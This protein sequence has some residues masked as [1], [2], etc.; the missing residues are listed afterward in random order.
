MGASGCLHPGACHF[1]V[2]SDRHL[3]GKSDRHFEGKSDRH[4]KG[5]KKQA[6]VQ[7]RLFPNNYNK[8]NILNNS[9]TVRPEFNL[10]YP[11]TV[12]RPEVSR[13]LRPAGAC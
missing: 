13:I 6:K 3:K 1:W 11:Q 12:C 9:G 4:P 8:L 2:K 7:F 5:T 10:V